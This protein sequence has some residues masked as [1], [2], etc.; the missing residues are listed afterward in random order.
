MIAALAAWYCA[1]LLA[2]NS[3][4]R[5]QVHHVERQQGWPSESDFLEICVPMK[6]HSAPDTSVDG[7]DSRPADSQDAQH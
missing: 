6:V 5:I 1:Q 4:R 2:I 3:A 7:T